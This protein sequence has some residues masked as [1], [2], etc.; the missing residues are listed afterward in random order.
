[1]SKFLWSLVGV[2]LSFPHSVQAQATP[3]ELGYKNSLSSGLPGAGSSIYAVISVT[4][5]WLLGIF[6]FIAIIGF[7]ISGIQYLTAAGD[8]SQIETAKTNMKYS[9]VGVIVAL[10]GFLIVQA[11]DRWLSGLTNSF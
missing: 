10:S 6:G 1:M 5:S 4:L 11:V 3:W 9:V 8:D 2:I 7:V